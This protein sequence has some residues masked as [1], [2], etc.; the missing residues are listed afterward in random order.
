MNDFFGEYVVFFYKIILVEVIEDEGWRVIVEVIE[1]WE[2]M[3]KYVKDEMFGMYEC[4]L[5]KEKEVILF[6]WFDVRYR[7]VI[8]IEV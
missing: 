4:F 2:Y 3:K 7:S 1:E 8:G 5:N 6:K